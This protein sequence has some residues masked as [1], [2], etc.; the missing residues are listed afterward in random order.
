MS[1]IVTLA[2]GIGMNTA[3]FSVVNAVLLA[4]TVSQRGAAGVARHNESFKMEAV[5]GPDFLDWKQQ[6]QS[7]EK[8]AACNG[9]STIS[10]NGNADQAMTAS[11]TDD[12]WDHRCPAVAGPRLHAGERGVVVLGR[13]I[14]ERRLGSD[15]GIIGKTV[16]PRRPRRHSGGSDAA[17]VPLSSSRRRPQ[18][19]GK[20]KLSCINRAICRRPTRF[21]AATWPSSMW[22]R[23]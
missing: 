12:F 7:F 2:L 5:A 1:T 22:W 4:V 15:P 17:G 19:H 21:V 18:R 11:V 3:V 20:L 9:P 13:G 23:S 16:T 14:F 10:I 8:M 6:A